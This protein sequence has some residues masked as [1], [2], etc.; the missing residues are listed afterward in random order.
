MEERSH[1]EALYDEQYDRCTRLAL[2]IVHDR[3]VAE[4]IASEAF[5]RAWARWRRLGRDP[6]AAGWLLR[7]TTNLAIDA[8]RRRQALAEASDA[9][10]S[11]ADHATMRVALVQALQTLPRRQREAIAL[12]YLADLSESDVSA[13]LG[14]SAGSVKTHLHRGLARLRDSMGTDDEEEVRL[15][16]GS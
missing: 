3:A 12:R 4:E 14:V 13:A 6:R 10:L 15:V 1:F 16:P 9:D 11:P 8:T 7:V 5:A 2:R